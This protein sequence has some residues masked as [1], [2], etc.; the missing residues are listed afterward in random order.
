MKTFQRIKQIGWKA[1]WLK[2]KQLYITPSPEVKDLCSRYGAYE[3]LQRYKYACVNISLAKS[4]PKEKIIW[5]CWLQGEENAPRIVQCCID[6]IRKYAGDY[7]VVVLTQE[8]I[9]NYISI[10]EHIEQKHKAGIIT[11]THY[12]DFVRLLLLRQYGGIWIDATMMLTDELPHCILDAPVFVFKRRPVGNVEIE[13]CFIASDKNNPLVC[14]VLEV[15]LEYWRNEDKLISYSL[16]HLAWTMAA[17]SSKEME[18]MWN[19]VPYLPCELIDILMHELSLKYSAEK[20]KTICALS[21]IHKL[22]YKFEQFGID[23][24]TKGTF[25]DVLINENKPC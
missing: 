22:S 9:S 21:P 12:S 17:H 19:N 11:H 3:Y 13:T 2:F 18:N 1:A 20:W 5:T 6:S 15:L 16:I 25:Y 14:A 23:T 8:T 7:K 10:P 24:V 4:A